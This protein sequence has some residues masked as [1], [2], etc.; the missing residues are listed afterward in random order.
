MTRHS[1]ATEPGMVKC[2][3]LTQPCV[4]GI[5]APHIFSGM[6]TEP[7]SNRVQIDVPHNTPQI[8]RVTDLD[9][10]KSPH[11]DM[12][13]FVVLPIPTLRM[14]TCQALHSVGQGWFGEF[15]DEVEVIGHY[16]PIENRPMKGFD[17]VREER[18]EMLLGLRV[19]EDWAPADSSRDDMQGNP[20][21]LSAKSARHSTTVPPTDAR[22]RLG[23]TPDSAGVARTRD[24]LRATFRRNRQ[25]THTPTPIRHA[26]FGMGPDPIPNFDDELRNGV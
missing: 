8:G 20:Q 9:R 22:A 13:T 18:E 16:D 15:H 4:S 14:E 21:R 11:V 7:G 26:Q 6:G 25:S 10:P 12:A 24:D 23:S 3:G 19:F 5:P 17:D 1:Q 2:L